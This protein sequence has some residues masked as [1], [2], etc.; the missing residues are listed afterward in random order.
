MKLWKKLT[1]C[2]VVSLLGACSLISPL[3]VD[4][5]GVRR[6]VATAINQNTLLSISSRHVL[7]AYAKE[8]QKI[9]SSQYQSEDQQNRL[10]QD[11]AI[12]T[13]CALQKVSAKKLNWVDSKIFVLPEQQEKL[14]HNQTL[15]NNIHINSTEID[16]TNKF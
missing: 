8:Q 16:C 9:L 11:R 14:K 13:Y 6:D 7:V 3:V 4:Y 12:G 5:N 2:T 1:I 15:Q 10:A